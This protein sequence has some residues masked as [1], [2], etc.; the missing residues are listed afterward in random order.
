VYPGRNY[1][2]GD[3]GLVPFVLQQVI[4]YISTIISTV[5]FIE[6]TGVYDEK[7]KEAVEAFQAFMGL[8]VTGILD[9][10]TWNAFSEVY[11]TQRE[12]NN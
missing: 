1:S 5:P 2:L 6:I 8:N 7:T 3:E 11:Y 10:E 12:N 4:Q 9:E